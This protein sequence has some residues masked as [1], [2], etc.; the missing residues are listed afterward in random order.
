VTDAEP[1]KPCATCGRRIPHPK[2]DTSPKTKVFGVRVP[3]GDAEAFGELVDAAA[4]YLGAAGRPHDRYWTL[5]Y[6]LVALLQSPDFAE[7]LTRVER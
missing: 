6:A 4:G 2:K 7:A 1:G 5:H 3:V